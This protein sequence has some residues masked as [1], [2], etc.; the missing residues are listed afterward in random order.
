VLRKLREVAAELA[1]SIKTVR[2]LIERGSL[3]AA[4]LGREW[5]V[6][7]IDLLAFIEARKAFPRTKEQ[8]E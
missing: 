2:R 3:R 5:R 1:C 8:L 7:D 6:D 4:R